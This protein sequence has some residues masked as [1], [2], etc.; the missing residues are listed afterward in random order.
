MNEFTL[1]F[2]EKIILLEVARN[3]ICKLRGV[4]SLLPDTF[5][6]PIALEIPCG[7][8]VSLHVQDKLRGCYGRMISEDPLW[9]TVDEMS[10]WAA[11]R[12]YRFNPIT[13][14]EIQNL[15]IEISVLSPMKLIE[16]INEIE[17]GKHGVYIRKGPNSGVFLPQVAVET[18]WSLDEFL[19]HCARDKAGVGWD[20]WK[21]ADIYTFS[22]LIFSD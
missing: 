14:S 3:S 4:N 8:F 10:V 6:Y 18:G 20:G 19:G 9:K 13:A 7:A 1:S 17:L 11:S 2:D 12:D 16:D 15:K 21:S 5:E 22:A